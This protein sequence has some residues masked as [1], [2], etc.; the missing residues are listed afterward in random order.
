MV[1]VD[2]EEE[3]RPRAASEV[4]PNDERRQAQ[5]L[6]EGHPVEGRLAAGVKPDV[7]WFRAAVAS[8][9][10]VLSMTVSGIPGVDLS[11][12][13]FD[14]HGKRLVRVNNSKEGGGETLVN[15]GVDPGTYLFRV[16]AVKGAAAAADAAGYRVVYTLRAREEGEE[17]E[18]NWKA[19]LATPLSMDQEATGYLGWQTDTDWY[20]VE[21]KDV[22]AGGRLRLEFDGVDGVRA[23]LSIRG[24]DG[25]M[26][27]ERWSRRS[28]A[29]VLP[30]LAPPQGT[31][32]VV[33]R[34]MYD[35]NVETRYSLRVLTV[36]PT[37]AVELEPNDTPRQAT[38]LAVDGHIA[39][40]GIVAD[41]TDRDL[42]AIRVARAQPV[43][44]EAVPPLNVDL[45][46]ALVVD[47]K[48]VWEVDQGKAREKEVLPVVWIRP[49]FG[50]IQ[51]R[52]PRQVGDSSVSA[53]TPYHIRVQPLGDGAWEQEPNNEPGSATP[54]APGPNPTRGFL[55]PQEDVDYYRLAPATGRVLVVA[56]PSA[57]QQ[58]KLELL[59][60]QG[61]VAASAAG[62][63]PGAQVRLEGSAGVEYVLRVTGSASADQA[64]TLSYPIT[65]ENP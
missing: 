59:L 46:L 47:D 38:P 50:L 16:R 62:S 25:S 28:E 29:V 54:L 58:L 4:E 21:L 12:E 64:Y 30:N 37:G 27:Q 11:L 5:P 42:Y 26:I 61:G 17:V 31:S 39:M 20:R 8:A 51:V 22:V 49:P 57:A 41:T 48:T 44:V 45:A 23:A 52:S 53:V 19:A 32:F 36:V 13:G 63:T 18:P 34:C 35:F 56:Q 7:D 14:D 43:R 3:N 9:G 65:G 40:A 60:P 33:V 15:L 10:Q 55:H 6:T 2:P 1:V 24:A